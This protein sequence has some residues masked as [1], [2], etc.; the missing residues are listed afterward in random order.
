MS[1]TLPFLHLG[2]ALELAHGLGD[3]VGKVDSPR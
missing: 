2:L 1:W 3:Q